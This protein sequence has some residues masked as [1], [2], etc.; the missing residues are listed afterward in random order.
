M[1]A[2]AVGYYAIL[3]MLIAIVS[4]VLC[5]MCDAYKSTVSFIVVAALTMGVSVVEIPRGL[6]DDARASATVYLDNTWRH[7]YTID[8]TWRDKDSVRFYSEGK[9]MYANIHNNGSI[10]VDNSPRGRE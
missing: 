6:V 9:Q 8:P 7:P 2:Y 10:T 1:S 4:A 3:T 5:L